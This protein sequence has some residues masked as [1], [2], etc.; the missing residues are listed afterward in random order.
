MNIHD[1][2]KPK[3]VFVALVLSCVA[4]IILRLLHSP[5]D[6]YMSEENE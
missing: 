5:H 6:E 1:I 3:N 4:W 2:E